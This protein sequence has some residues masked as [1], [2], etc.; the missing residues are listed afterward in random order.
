MGGTATL[1]GDPPNI[2]IGSRAHLTFNEFLLNLG[3]VV[4]IIFIVFLSTVYLLFRTRWK[5]ADN[6]K[7][8]VTNALPH[9]AIVDRKRMYRALV[10]LGF[11]FLGFLTQGITGLGS[12]IIALCGSM[13]MLVICSSKVDS[14][15][16]RVEWGVVARIVFRCP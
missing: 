1:I 12:G 15:L 11:I 7:A 5:V 10:I 8:R 13:F 9:L 14:T 4:L 2:L 3:F 16:A 6:V